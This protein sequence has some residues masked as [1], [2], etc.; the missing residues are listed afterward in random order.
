MRKHRIVTAIIAL[1][2]LDACKPPQQAAV[3]RADVHRNGSGD[4][5]I[6]WDRSAVPVDVYVADRPDAPRGSMRLLVDNDEDGRA[7]LRLK[8][9]KR[10]YFY[11]AAD[12]GSGIW[13]AERVLPLEGGLNFR[14]LGGYVTR[15]GRRIQWGKLYRSG[16]MAGLTS[17]D[18][19]YLSNLGVKVVCDLR[20][21]QERNAEPNRWVAAQ[22]IPILARDYDFRDELANYSGGEKF[23]PAQLKAAMT[24]AYRD[25]PYQLASD[26]QAIFKRLAAGEL[27]LAFNCSGGKDRT[28]IGAALLLS[29]LGVPRDTIIADYLLTNQALDP[30]QGFRKTP[31]SK[32]ALQP[33]LKLPEEVR[34]PLLAADA[35]YLRA[36]FASIE[37]KSGTLE[38]YFRQTLGMTEDE[39]DNMR[40]HLLQ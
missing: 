25:L 23:K 10:P 28:G 32:S 31:V 19:Q 16:S 9:S 8:T 36:T 22:K 4:F 6:A 29:A 27:P 40:K 12:G 11:V 18:Y 26:Y 5:L 15:D 14:D 24:Q 21:T 2:A 17:T 35:D 13:A 1:G 3:T 33:W 39:L 20:T 37:Q 34:A 38:N 7:A 30:R